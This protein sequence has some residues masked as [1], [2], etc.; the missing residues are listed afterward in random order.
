MISVKTVDDIDEAIEHINEHGTRHSE[1]I[2]TEK[3]ENAEDHRACAAMLAGAAQL[4]LF[5][6]SHARSPPFTLLR[7]NSGNSRSLNSQFRIMITIRHS[8]TR[9]AAADRP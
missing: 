6:R 8:S 2:M 1:C 9:I 3:Q 4:M 7:L 5:Q